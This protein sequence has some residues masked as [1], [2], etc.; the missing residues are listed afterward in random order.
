MIYLSFLVCRHPWYTFPGYTY[1]LGTY[2]L[3]TY[4][5]QKGPGTRDTYPPEGTWD[6]RYISPGRDLEQTDICENITFPQRR[7]RAVKI[8]DA[9]VRMGVRFVKANYEFALLGLRSW[10]GSFTFTLKLIPVTSIQSQI[11]ANMKAYSYCVE[12]I[13]NVIAF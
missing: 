9:V 7:W 4:P 2:P 6:Q 3:D 8:T 1:P 11:H 5:P 12:V 13:A 10:N